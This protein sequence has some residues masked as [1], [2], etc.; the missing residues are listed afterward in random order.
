MVAFMVL[1]VFLLCRQINKRD[2]LK[3]HENGGN[4]SELGDGHCS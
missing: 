1:V 2:N 4:Y 3:K